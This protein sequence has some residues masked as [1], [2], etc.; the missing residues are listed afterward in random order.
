MMFLFWIPV[1]IL[2]YWLYKKYD[3]KDSGTEN[4][5]A[6]DILKDRYAK[7]EINKREF[8]KKKKDLSNK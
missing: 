8:E 5:S 2:I 7:G 3:E 4:R 1:I 6:L